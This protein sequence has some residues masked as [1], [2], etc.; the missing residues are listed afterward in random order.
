MNQKGL[1]LNYILNTAVITHLAAC[2]H[3]SGLD[4]P[5]NKVG[6]LTP[7]YLS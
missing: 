7:I 2:K 3:I 1:V 6:N 5:G 4:N